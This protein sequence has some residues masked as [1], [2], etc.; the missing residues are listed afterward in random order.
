MN[1]VEA[2]AILAETTGREAPEVMSMPAFRDVLDRGQMEDLTAYLRARFA[3]EKAWGDVGRRRSREID[4]TLRM[5]R[6][7]GAIRRHD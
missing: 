6:Q 4:G 1:G 2:P 7:G 3:P 5:E